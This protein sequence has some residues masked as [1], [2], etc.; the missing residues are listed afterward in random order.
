[1]P[2]KL[3]TISVPRTNGTLGNEKGIS[4]IFQLYLGMYGIYVYFNEFIKLT[5][6]LAYYSLSQKISRTYPVV[7][8]RFM[9]F[10]ACR[11]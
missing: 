4:L 5:I 6:I 8:Q 7:M 2:R 11:R 3:N 9:K 10:G 1:L